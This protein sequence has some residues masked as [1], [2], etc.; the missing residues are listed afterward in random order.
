MIPRPWLQHYAAGVPDEIDDSR[1][2]SLVALLDERFALY[3]DRV[4][5]ML[6]GRSVTFGDM[7]K[8]NVGKSRCRRSPPRRRRRRR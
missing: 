7:L 2:P 5:N 3:S 6:A 4:A 8:S 1:Y